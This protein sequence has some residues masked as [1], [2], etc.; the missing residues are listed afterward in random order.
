MTFAFI[1]EPTVFFVGAICFALAC[2]QV[3]WMGYSGW[4][5]RARFERNYNV[6]KHSF[7]EQ[8]ATTMRAAR[9]ANS[10]LAAWQGTR[11]LVVSAIVDEA[12]GVKSF[13][14]VDPNG[15]PLPTFEP[16]Q[17]LTLHLPI[18]DR[19]K[20]VVRCYSLSD[21]PREQFYRITIKRCPAPTHAP[22]LPAGRASNW[23]HDF[24]T[25]GT[26]IETAA[27]G[28]AFFL[29][30]FSKPRDDEPVVLVAGGVGITPLASMLTSIAASEPSRPV[31]LFYGV[32]NG[33]EHIFR[34]TL[35]DLVNDNDRI[36]QFVA[37]SSPDADDRAGVD[38]TYRGRLTA[39]VI[40]RQL[41]PGK[42]RYY[43]C[44][45]P[46]MM[47]S[48][49]VGLLELGVSD[50]HI[51]FEAF[52]PASV[53]RP[54]REI[55]EPVLVRFKNGGDECQWTGEFGSLLELAEA[56]GIDVEFGCRAG[57]CGQCA[58][59]VVEGEV[60]TARQPGVHLPAGQCLLCISTPTSP[61]VLEV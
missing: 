49:V 4:Q 1:A 30:L 16:G 7:R 33:R 12:E 8:V 39:E 48:L 52:G 25:I 41:P 13:Y 27:P 23:L 19:G 22:Q 45:P 26:T 6:Q 36:T 38:Y 17:Y 14:L 46:S 59:Q 40:K 5:R 28:G 42:Y 47:Q 58:V 9:A 31:W 56:H 37:Y 43:L 32:R 29:D 11:S 15:R 50:D 54:T 60:E 24:A 35:L 51:H 2:A 20:T 61:V 3:A 44:G 10:R 53:T 57:N 34:D 21:R 18:G 55:I